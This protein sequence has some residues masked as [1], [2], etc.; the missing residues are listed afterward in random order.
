MVGFGR[1]LHEVT[2]PHLG[3]V[4]SQGALHLPRLTL[5]TLVAHQHDGEFHLVALDLVD[6]F[7]DGPQLLQTLA[8]GD[9]VYQDE[10]MTLT[11]GQPLHGRE[12]V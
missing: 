3:L 12:L 2:L 11:D 5:V 10:G 7:P 6:D 9:R 8:R 4:L 1:G